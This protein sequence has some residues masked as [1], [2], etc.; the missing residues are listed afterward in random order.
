M[1][2]SFLFVLYIYTYIYFFLNINR[3]IVHAKLHLEIVNLHEKSFW[4]WSH[5]DVM[6][7]ICHSGWSVCGRAHVH[8]RSCLCDHIEALCSLLSLTAEHIY[9]TLCG[10]A[11]LCSYCHG[12]VNCMISHH[13]L[14]E[15]K[16]FRFITVFFHIL[17]KSNFW[18]LEGMERKKKW[19]DKIIIF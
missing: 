6:G 8:Y 18:I 13:P 19:C 9:L 3:V 10:P 16:E 15:I 7:L 17:K 5:W 12:K 1:H 2:F 11:T 14:N 4:L